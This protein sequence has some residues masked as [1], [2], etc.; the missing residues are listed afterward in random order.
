LNLRTDFYRFI[1][2]QFNRATADDT[3]TLTVDLIGLFCGH[4]APNPY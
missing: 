1:V 3:A 2:E 4:F